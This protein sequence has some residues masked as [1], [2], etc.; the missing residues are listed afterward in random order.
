MHNNSKGN[1]RVYVCVCFVISEVC[2]CVCVCCKE[3]ENELT[4][5]KDAKKNHAIKN[6]YDMLLFA[7]RIKCADTCES[8]KHLRVSVLQR[9]PVL[10]SDKCQPNMLLFYFIPR[11]RAA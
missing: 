8:E 4:Q 10:T 2:M 7:F 1:I 3:R 6:K 11:R 9:Q 5:R